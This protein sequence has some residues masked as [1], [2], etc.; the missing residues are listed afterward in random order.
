MILKKS[1]NFIIQLS[2]ICTIFYSAPSSA[3]NMG[4]IRENP[5][6][7]KVF[8]KPL[9]MIGNG[10]HN[11][12]FKSKLKILKRYQKKL[13]RT[14]SHFRRNKKLEAQTKLVGTPRWVTVKY[15]RNKGYSWKDIDFTVFAMTLFAEAKNLDKEGVEMVARVINNRRKG[16]SYLQ[17]TTQLAQFS[18]WYYKNQ[19]DNVITLCPGKAYHKYWKKIIS[20]AKKQFYKNDNILNS[21]NYFAPH[22]MVPRYRIPVWAK[23][24][25]AIGFGGHI[26]LVKKNFKWHEKNKKS[27][28]IPKNAKRI[29]IRR[30]KIS[31]LKA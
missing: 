10:K 21:T 31:L 14:R 7:Y 30:G 23:G 25:H 27:I 26:F 11:Q 24:R 29:K 5:L 3:V 1:I 19:R 22:N 4:S 2:I 18:S 16:R 15:M 8:E 12:S 9:C 13:K 6:N 17:I 28:F 20:V